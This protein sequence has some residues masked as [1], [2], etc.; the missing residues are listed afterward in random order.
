[1]ALF[2]F[3]LNRFNLYIKGYVIKYL[4]CNL[5]EY[6]LKYIITLLLNFYSNN[7]FREVLE[8]IVLGEQ[9]IYF[10]NSLIF[11]LIPSAIDVITFIVY[12]L[13]FIDVYI[14]LII[15]DIIVIYI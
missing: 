4:M 8:V 2:T 14:G 3:I 15:I 13:H 1:M 10:I 6:T 7:S 11:D 5:K 12:F 9:Y